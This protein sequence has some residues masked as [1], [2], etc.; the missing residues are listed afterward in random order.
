MRQ[1]LP[2]V[3]A[4]CLFGFLPG[5]DLVAEPAAP[6]DGTAAVFG[7]DKLWTFHLE[8]SAK[9]W[10]AMHP[11]RGGVWGGQ[12]PPRERPPEDRPPAP[13]RGHFGYDFPYVKA[14][15]EIDGRKLKD[16]AVRFKGNSSYMMSA[17]G[18]KRPFKIDFDRFV[19]EQ[20]FHGVKK[21]NLAN[22]AMDA[23]QLRESLAYALFHAAGVPAPRT[24]FVELYLTVPGKYERE[25]AGLYTL[26]EQ[27]DKPFLKRHFK[28]SK[29]MLLK[30]EGFQNLPYL[31]REWKVYASLY[32]PEDEPDAAAQERLIEFVRLVNF[33]DDAEFVRRIGDFMD[34]DGYLRYLA[35]CSVT[36][37]LDSFVGLGHNYYLYLRPE[38]NRFVW[39]PWDVNASFCGINL[40]G[41]VEQQV[42]WSIKRPYMGSNRLTERLLAI[43]ENE[44]AYRKHLGDL[45]AGAFQTERVHALIELMEKTVKK[46]LAKEAE[47][48]K[49]PERPGMF[50]R[51]PDLKKFVSQRGESLVSQ[52]AGKSE[53]KELRMG[54]GM[55][56][57]RGGLGGQLSKPIL[58]AAD[59]D[60][61][62]KLSRD[63]LS[64][65]LRQLF[66][67]CDKDKKGVV[68]EKSFAGELGKLLPRQQGFGMR[69]PPGVGN[70]LAVHIAGF[71]FKRAK[72]DQDRLTA[73]A[74]VAWAET[75][76][77]E[78]DKNTD[79]VLDSK[80][81]NEALNG[82]PP[83]P[84][85]FGMLGGPRGDAPPPRMP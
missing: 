18:I 26:I 21:I 65:G 58:D 30:P 53:G 70:L 79:G 14:D 51:S 75:L 48:K 27:V 59:A 47:K 54:F 35:V 80:E 62:G 46:T 25:L 55:A 10:E 6:R 22:N 7:P 72:V 50:G 77:Q 57:A 64:T 61:D 63:E 32:R 12:P 36:V 45:A 2:A 33:A 83:P 16:V 69:P 15:L 78:A 29:G 73:D 28:S 49:E 76:F 66:A 31:G 42:D 43:K 24:A 19:E 68:D 41:S 44:N 39:I 84:Q 40:G 82:L 23:S 4:A 85:V 13:P 20:S 52:L 8:I 5:I 67:A 17:Q 11:T 34:I 37:N 74:F 1:R 60:K 3:L 56:A 81:L 38:D 71:I 9:D